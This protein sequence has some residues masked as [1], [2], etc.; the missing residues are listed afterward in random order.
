MDSLNEGSN[1][2]ASD[3][4]RSARLTHHLHSLAYPNSDRDGVQVLVNSAQVSGIHRDGEEEEQEVEAV[5]Q[6]ALD[7][8]AGVQHRQDAR[9]ASLAQ[10]QSGDGNSSI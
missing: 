3:C 1:L 8:D 6:S 9:Q 10:Q 4:L 5:Q 2:E 7:I